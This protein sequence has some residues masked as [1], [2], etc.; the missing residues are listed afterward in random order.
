MCPQACSEQCI[1]AFY[2]TDRYE[3]ATMGVLER[4]R[5]R[6]DYHMPGDLQITPT[7][8]TSQTWIDLS[9]LFSPLHQAFSQTSVQAGPT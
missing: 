9:M 2:Y 8:Q 7:Q 3:V 4:L 6:Q 1:H 5:P